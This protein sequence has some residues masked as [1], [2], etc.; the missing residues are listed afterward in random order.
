[1]ANASEILHF[2]KMDV[3]LCSGTYDVQ[4]VLKQ[5]VDSTFRCLT[6]CV[7]QELNYV[8]PAFLDE[9]QDADIKNGKQD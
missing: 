1:M 3:H 6:H 8:M 4:T 2:L 9:S 7:E 5:S